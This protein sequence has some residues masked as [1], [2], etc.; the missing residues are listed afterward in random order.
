MSNR[1]DQLEVDI[2]ALHREIDGRPRSAERG[3]RSGRGRLRSTADQFLVRLQQKL[4][5]R[6]AWVRNGLERGWFDDFSRYWSEQ[7][8]GRPLWSVLDFFLLAHDYRKRQQLEDTL[9]WSE[10]AQHIRNWQRP[11]QVYSTFQ[12]GERLAMNPLP[13]LPFW[14]TVRSAGARVL[15]Y[16][17]SAAPFY[18]AYRRFFR[19]RQQSWTL[20]D[21]PNYP[22]HYAKWLYREDPEVEFVTIDP[23]NFTDPLGRRGGYDA[24]VLTT[25]LE[26]VDDPVRVVQDL[27][28]RLAP[29][30]ILLFDFV[31]SEGTGLDHP[32]ARDRR[33]EALGWLEAQGSPVGGPFPPKAESV[34][35]TLLRKQG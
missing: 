30:G 7:L 18:H 20:V 26:H 29:G 21:L 23:E 16:G 34:P 25:V 13:F 31:R 17:C 1:F 19:Y 14:R 8:G 2:D 5:L 27:W 9:A 24:V 4:S 28:G 15:E 3:V 22:F 32:V 10:G 33:E 35:P 11:G 12:Q 6:E